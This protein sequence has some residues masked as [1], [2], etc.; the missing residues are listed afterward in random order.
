LVGGGGGLE[1]ASYIHCHVATTHYSTSYFLSTG[2][3]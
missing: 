3:Y 2:F 1:L